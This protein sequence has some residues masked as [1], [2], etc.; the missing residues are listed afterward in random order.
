M[1]YLIVASTIAV[2]LLSVACILA[3]RRNQ[4]LS[5]QIRVL[6]EAHRDRP[7]TSTQEPVPARQATPDA[8][9]PERERL[10]SFALLE[11]HLGSQLAAHRQSGSEVPRL[12]RLRLNSGH[13]TR[14]QVDIEGWTGQML[15]DLDRQMSQLTDAL[16]G[17][18]RASDEPPPTQSETV[19]HRY[20]VTTVEAPASRAALP[21]AQEKRLEK[22]VVPLPP[23][24]TVYERLTKDDDI[25]EE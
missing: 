7:A 16:G 24:P 6:G 20:T 4:R 17:L 1:I 8:Q 13:A 19:F 9:E 15:A 14:S 23:S 2:L 3:N 21:E 22:K 25:I 12:P 11:Q 10:S 5:D 18:A